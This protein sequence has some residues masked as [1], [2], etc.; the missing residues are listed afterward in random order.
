MN[1]L[2]LPWKIEILRAELAELGGAVQQLSQ[3]GL[4]SAS[5]RLLMARKRAE[6]EDVMKQVRQCQSIG[7]SPTGVSTKLL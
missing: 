4:D 5:A 2:P 1:D 7:D 6:L 3:S